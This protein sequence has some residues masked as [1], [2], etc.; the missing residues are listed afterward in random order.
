MWFK[1]HC[2]AIGPSRHTCVCI[3]PHYFGANSTDGKYCTGFA[4]V[5][6][7]HH[8]IGVDYGK[9][10][11]ELPARNYTYCR[12]MCADTGNCV[13]FTFSS[14]SVPHTCY[15]STHVPLAS[16]VVKD[17]KSLVRQVGCIAVPVV[18]V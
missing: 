7:G 1:S 11:I 3:D 16:L 10:A 5:G 15:Y 4:A 14:A 18:F 2:V 17:T 8:S 13:T 6:W 9:H 12:D